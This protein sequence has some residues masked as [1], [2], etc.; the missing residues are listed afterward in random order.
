MSDC[1]H[2]LSLSLFSL[3]NLATTTAA[4]TTTAADVN[5]VDMHAALLDGPSYI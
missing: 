5:L 4:T 1:V 3:H 2:S